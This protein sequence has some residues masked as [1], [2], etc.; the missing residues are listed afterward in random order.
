[1]ADLGRHLNAIY[2]TDGELEHLARQL[3]SYGTLYQQP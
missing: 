1:M 2:T 3:R